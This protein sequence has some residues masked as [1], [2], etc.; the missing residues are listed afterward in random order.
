MTPRYPT[1]SLISRGEHAKAMKKTG[2]TLYKGS[3]QKSEKIPIDIIDD[4]T[5]AFNVQILILTVKNYDLEAAAKDISSKLHDEPIIV[6]LQNGVENQFILPKFFS[7]IVYGVV[8]YSA[9]TL[10]PGVVRYQSRGPIY[11]GTIDNKLKYSIEEICRIFNLGLEAEITRRLQDTVNCKIVLNLTN[12]L[13]T[14]V[15]LNYQEISSY[16]KL[17]AIASKLLNEGI[18]II[19]A[20]GCKEYP[21]KNYPSWRTLRFGLRL[22]SFIRTYVLRRTV[23]HAILNSMGQDVLFKRKK[24]T[25]LES[26]NRYIL[27]VADSLGIDAP[28]NRTLYSICKSAFNRPDFQPLSIE[29]LWDQLDLN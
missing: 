13:F 29:K 26:F 5:E 12:A 1:V 22:P 20:A 17:A 7:K 21:M 25:E 6:A 11:L 10:K 4:L 27:N 14:L 16:A 19:Q 8:G 3:S 24:K 23:K 9:M 18:D 15:G 2:L 28:L